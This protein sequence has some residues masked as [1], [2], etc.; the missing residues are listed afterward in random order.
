M[1]HLNDAIVRL[2]DT[3]FDRAPDA[4]GLAFWNRVADAGYGLDYM[5]AQFITAPEFAATYGQPTN[6][7]FVQE[8]YAN[9]LDRA[10]EAEGVSFWTRVLDEGLAG[11]AREVIE[12]SESAEHVAQLAAAAPPA[13]GENSDRKV[14]YFG[15]DGPDVVQGTPSRE[16]FFGGG[17]NDT[18][19]G[20]AGDDVLH[21]EGGD[22]ELRGDEGSDLL[23]G[24]A[25]DDN[26]WGG[27]GDDTL[28]G[29]PGADYMWARQHLQGAEGNDV[30]RF[31]APGDVQ[32]D[33]I[34]DFRA[35]NLLDFRPLQVAFRGTGAF[36]ADGRAQLRYDADVNTVPQRDGPTAPVSLDAD[37][38]GRADA[39]MVVR[40]AALTDASFLI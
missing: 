39:A 18:L 37:G 22:D 34:V 24:G 32:G 38:D 16:P 12:F 19:R 11:R 40:G 31:D 27:A 2:Y 15:T 30:F 10:G 33:V 25:G 26:L 13:S 5:A 17:G 1:V 6:L 35:G 4:D 36:E 21:G 3:V 8:M 28:A 7:A 23:V 29:G 20:G 14:P 9:V